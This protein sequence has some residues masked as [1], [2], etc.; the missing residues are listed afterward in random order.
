MVLGIINMHLFI[1]KIIRNINNMKP[2]NIC[3]ANLYFPESVDKICDCKDV[4]KFTPPNQ[5]L[6][7]KKLNTYTINKI[8]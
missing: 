2:P 4:C 1:S 3:Y 5:Q 6:Y 7:I 8:N